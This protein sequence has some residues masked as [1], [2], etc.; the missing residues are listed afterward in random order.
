MKENKT[1]KRSK[2]TQE[3]VL[4]QIG[5]KGITENLM[6]ELEDQLKRKKSVKIKILKNSP[7]NSR[8]E[9]FE[10]LRQSLPPKAKI[11]EIKGWTVI[12]NSLE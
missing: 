9:A 8:E 11:A 2:F 10:A 4:L 5:K 6:V 7:Y 1:E 12:I 3:S